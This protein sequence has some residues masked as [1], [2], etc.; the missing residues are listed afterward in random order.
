MKAGRPN[1]GDDDEEVPDGPDGGD[2]AVED[3]EGGLNLSDEDQLLVSV[4]VIK[5][6]VINPRCIVHF[7]SEIE[8]RTLWGGIRETCSLMIWV[9]F[10]KEELDEGN[11][12]SKVKIIGVNEL[13]YFDG[14]IIE[15]LDYQVK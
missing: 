5:A 4:A 8:L 13:D 9:T 12:S 7:K 10:F 6:A 1:H 15:M 14:G 3:E 2:Q 11:H